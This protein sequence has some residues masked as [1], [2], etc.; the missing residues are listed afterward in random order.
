MGHQRV[1]RGRPARPEPPLV[2]T[3]RQVV[4]TDGI[5]AAAELVE[6]AL[7]RLAGP[8]ALTADELGQRRACRARFGHYDPT[9]QH[10]I[11]YLARLAGAAER[12]AA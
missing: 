4:A 9:N 8:W 11:L 1:N 7:D 5:G 3:L 10:H 6:T 2:E 12:M